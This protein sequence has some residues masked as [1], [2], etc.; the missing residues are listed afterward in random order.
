LRA[1]VTLQQLHDIFAESKSFPV[2]LEVESRAL[3]GYLSDATGWIQ[4]NVDTLVTLGIPITS[5]DMS[6]SAEEILN[7]LGGSLAESAD[8]LTLRVPESPQ[9]S[10]S[11]LADEFP[12]LRRV[13]SVQRDSA[14][15][16]SYADVK[17]L[18]ESAHNITVSFPE[19]RSV[20][21]QVISK[22]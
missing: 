3:R 8:P 22:I 19:L 14:S 11:V 4:S 18:V 6:L 12:S 9:H 17:L 16:V 21:M 7:C 13:N 15:V 10:D 5:T 20:V 1:G 2:D